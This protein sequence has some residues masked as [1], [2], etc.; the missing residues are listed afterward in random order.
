[1]LAED[2]IS[3]SHILL[4]FK[5][6][7]AFVICL[8]SFLV[9]ILQ[10]PLGILSLLDEESNAPN[11]TD[12]TLAS[13]LKQHLNSNSYF[14]GDRGRAFGVRH[15]AGEVSY[16]SFEDSLKFFLGFVLSFNFKGN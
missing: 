3:L 15:F 2:F 9:F 12:F 10:K 5:E 14:K 13:K 11:S 16:W 7:R 4:H 1:M 6:K 8:S